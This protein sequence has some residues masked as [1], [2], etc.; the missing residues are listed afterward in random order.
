MMYILLDKYLEKKTLKT[1][2]LSTL[3]CLTL[4][5]NFLKPF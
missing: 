1:V 3:S 2:N 4:S 5:N